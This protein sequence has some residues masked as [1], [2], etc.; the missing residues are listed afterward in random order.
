VV[1]AGCLVERRG[2]A[3]MADV[4]GLGG[5]LGT[6]RVGS[7][8]DVVR[9]AVAGEEPVVAG[10]PGHLP[11]HAPPR[12][13]TTPRH[14]A[15]L[16][17]AEGCANRCHYC[18][19]PSLR[20]DLKSRPLAAVGAEAAQL[21]AAGAREIVLVA[22][23]TT[24]WGLDLGGAPRLADLVRR[25]GGLLGL[26]WLRV[27]Y[28]HP[29]RVSAD[30]LAALAGS[31]AACRYLDV[32]LQHASPRVLRAM[33]R[34]G[35]GGDEFMR[36]L[37]RVRDALPGVALRTTFLAGFPGEDEGDVRELEAFVAASGFDHAGVF[38]FSPQPGTPAA[39]LAG[40]VPAA[41][42]AER[43]ARIYR[44]Q[45]AAALAGA[46]RR[47]G[48]RLRA[49]VEGTAGRSVAPPDCAGGEDCGAGSAC[50]R[51]RAA[52]GRWV[53]GRAVTQAP[54]VDGRSY[55]FGAPKT[56]GTFV[57]ATVAGCGPYHLCA[58]VDA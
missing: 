43:A 51:A 46:R 58:I 21:L 33:G 15:Y 19:I 26:E 25:L 18:L 39:G 9:A 36:L 50:P 38:A 55:L 6:G 7:V 23:D 56:P 34:G 37:E 12:L 31:P 54:E 3:I 24:R 5:A 8:V 30:L 4:P 52:G 44:A 11:R 29:A 14:Y 1:A 16:K 2:A 17:I 13:L 53:A 10:R 42:A 47:L 32:P 20:G 45:R 49:V 57:D 41:V 48:T 35:G 27:M 28:A 40:Q 22:Q